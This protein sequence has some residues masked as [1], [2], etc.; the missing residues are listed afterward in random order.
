MVRKRILALFCACMM[1]AALLAG[2]GSSSE[3]TSEGS[4]DAAEE[5]SSEEALGNHLNAALYWFG[6]SL[7]PATEYDGW[8]TSRAGI[9]ETLV[10]V[11]E[12]YELQPKLADS[13]EQTDDTTWVM[14]IREGVTF[15]DGSAVDGEAVKASL[16]RAMETQERAVTAAKIDTIE[17]DGQ[18][19]T[20]T[21]S[22]PFGAF[23]ANLSEPLYSIVKV[24]DD[25]DY[26]NAPIGTGPF[27]VTDFTVNDT[28]E[29]VRYD[30]YWDGASS[31]ESVTIKCITEDSTRGLALQS[32]EQDIVQRVASTDLTTFLNDDNY[33][34]IETTGA[35][36]RILAMNENVEALADENVRAAIAA[37]IDY[38][39]LVSVLGEVVTQA[40][41]PFPASSP[42][43]Y[44]DLDKQTYDPTA[45]AE[46]L[47]A[48]GYEDADGD[49]IVEK[50]GE[51]LSL[52]LTYALADYTTM[53]EAVQSM[54]KENGI[55]IQLNLVDDIADSRDS[56]NFELLCTNW[57]SLSTGD[58]QWFLETM[59]KS[60]GSGN[61]MSY[62]NA[63]LDEV[64]NKMSNTFTEDE[65][66]ALA[67]EAEEILLEDNP[68]IW[69]LGEKNFVVANAKVGNITAYPIDYYFLDNK[70][71]IA[72]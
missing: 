39:S 59:Y 20:I 3:T 49:G 69:A 44:D 25:Q 26:A 27:M 31:I 23:L 1:G 63:E 43:G 9:T 35:R 5:S 38:D 17:A 2:C 47:A 37:S 62:S 18:E 51:P 61:C 36:V 46:A 41:A 60:D 12:N 8:T 6:T 7:D 72:S 11:D 57:Q 70:V 58:P 64:I 67:I 4:S 22:E 55:E 56:Q 48:A 13:W 34:T 15:H 16:E 30:D 71:T 50:D 21:T 52:S 68:C 54:L 45:A 42:Y 32:G 14:H 33:Q 24:D 19:V 53:L 40:G 29:E 10:V 65:R 28:I 66:T